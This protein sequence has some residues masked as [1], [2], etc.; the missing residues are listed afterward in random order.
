MARARLRDAGIRD[1][2]G[3]LALDAVALQ[4][5]FDDAHEAERDRAALR[6]RALAGDG[7]TDASRWLVDALSPT[8]LVAP[9]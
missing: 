1:W 9:K 7:A 5:R 6:A 4:R 3:G 8:R 2:I